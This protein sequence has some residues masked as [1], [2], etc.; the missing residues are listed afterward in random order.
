M[1]RIEARVRALSASETNYL[2]QQNFT[3]VLGRNDPT[4]S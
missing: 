2:G 4:E 3:E 1:T